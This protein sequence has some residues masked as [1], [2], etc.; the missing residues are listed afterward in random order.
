[1]ALACFLYGS[2]QKAVIPQWPLVGCAAS[3]IPP[4]ASLGQAC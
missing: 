3:W 4:A 2:P 1:L